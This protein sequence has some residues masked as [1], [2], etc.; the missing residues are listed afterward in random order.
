M[1]AKALI[2]VVAVVL[3]AAG[4]GYYY[5]SNHGGET[6]PELPSVLDPVKDDSDPSISYLDDVDTDSPEFV[7][8]LK[9]D[10]Y[11]D[12]AKDIKR[13]GQQKLDDLSKSTNS[14]IW[15]LL[16]QI[17]D[18]TAASGYK[19][20]G[21]LVS[22]NQIKRLLDSKGDP[23]ES[24]PSFR[25]RCILHY[26]SW[27]ADTLYEKINEVYISKLPKGFTDVFSEYGI[28]NDYEKDKSIV[29]YVCNNVRTGEIR[30]PETKEWIPYHEFEGNPP[31]G[32]TMEF[33]EALYSVFDGKMYD[34]YGH[35]CEFIYDA[36]SIE[37]VF[38]EED[39]K[40]IFGPNSKGSFS[41]GYVYDNL[42][43]L[44]DSSYYHLNNCLNEMPA[45]YSDKIRGCMDR[46]F[47]I[48]ENYPEEVQ[49]LEAEI[50]KQMAEL[51][52][53]KLE[54]YG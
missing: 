12:R 5:L 47:E 21:I 38:T 23:L 41:L 27:E 39:I 7:K 1:N 35:A 4:G 43:S 6:T 36:E 25:I 24:Y 48:F 9:D 53:E 50:Q 8:I 31:E 13:T 18:L 49:K 54:L 11:I 16:K 30:D 46:I 22:D 52:K 33:I 2:V 42:R 14:R 15:E 19:E 32:T 20:D 44:A 34:G 45:E 28:E 37:G 40:E 10:D 29:G 26:E 51:Q 17:D 3:V